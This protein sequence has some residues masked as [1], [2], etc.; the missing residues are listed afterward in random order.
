MRAVILAGEASSFAMQ[1]MRRLLF[2]AMPQFANV[3]RYEI[4]PQDVSAA[5]AAHRAR[6]TVID[7]FFLH[8]MIRVDSIDS[9]NIWPHEDL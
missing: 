1:D 5:G 9:G 7:D 3:F 2:K 6:Q 8:P 4:E